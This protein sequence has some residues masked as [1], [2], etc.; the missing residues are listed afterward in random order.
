LLTI[1]SVDSFQTEERMAVTR[2]S[3]KTFPLEFERIFEE[4]HDLVYRTAY[5]ITGHVQDAEDVAQTIFLRILRRELPVAS[6][7]N[8]AG[9]L[10]RAAVNLSLT[11]VKSRSRDGDVE[12]LAVLPSTAKNN[13]EEQHRALYETIATLPPR[14]AEILILR[15]QHNFSDVQIAKLL[16]TSRGVIAVTL[17]RARARLKKL[18][19]GS[20]GAQ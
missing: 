14:M 6:M 17:Y 10:Y 9:Y 5:G 11:I 20:S 16:G 1:A 13:V 7:E 8:P 12:A 19:A 15:Y 2:V 18:L 3:G 4:H